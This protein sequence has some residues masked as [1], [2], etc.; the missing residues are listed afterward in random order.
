MEPKRSTN[1]NVTL[2]SN[3]AVE[4][5]GFHACLFAELVFTDRFAGAFNSPTT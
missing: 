4:V 5:L 3:L 2:L 1:T